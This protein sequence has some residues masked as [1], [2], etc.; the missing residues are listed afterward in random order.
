VEG[1][2]RRV[3]RGEEVEKRVE[4]GRGEGV[5]KGRRGSVAS[6][7]EYGGGVREWKGGRRAR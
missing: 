6:V 2:G 3:G 7:E 4:R 5:G 1:G